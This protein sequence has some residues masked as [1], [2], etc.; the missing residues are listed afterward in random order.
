MTF[1]IER[2]VELRRHLDHLAL[3]REL[4]RL[5]GFRNVLVRE[6]VVLDLE[7][8]IDAVARLEP[9]REFVEIVRNLELA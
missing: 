8:V 6:Y 7:R 4:E 1:L 2:L 9:V 5:P 3:V